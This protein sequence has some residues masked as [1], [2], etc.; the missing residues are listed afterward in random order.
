MYIDVSELGLPEETLVRLTDDEGAGAFDAAR[1]E[2]AISAAQA[3]M[4]CVLSRQYAVPLAEPDG[5]VKKLTRDI[6]VFNLYSR[7][8]A[9]PADVRAAYEE[10]GRWLKMAGAGELYIGLSAPSPGPVSV[11]EERSFSRGSMCGF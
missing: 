6:A 10:A 5:A 9:V 3:V 11:S 7:V 1:A 2:S 4:D 8:G